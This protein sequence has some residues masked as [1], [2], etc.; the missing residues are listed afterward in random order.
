MNLWNYLIGSLG[1]LGRRGD[2]PGYFDLSR[3]GLKLS[4]LALLLSVPCYYVCA[5]AIQQQ[6]ASLS[7]NPPVYPTT[8]FFLILGLYA[9][10][11]VVCAYIL[12]IVFDRMDSFR[13]W[14][15]TRHWSVFYAA[16]LAAIFSGLFIVGVVPFVLL[17][18]GLMIIYLGTLAIDIR[19]AQKIAGFEWGAAIL[20][21]CII[22][23]MSLT[24]LLIGVAQIGA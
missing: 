18:G 6:S 20:A 21:G 16:L 15:I 4:F 14:V 17:Y 10:M 12:S 9:L 24:I 22:T 2:W 11:F 1:A 8:P 19:L 13:A 3:K 23:A 5:I 7:G